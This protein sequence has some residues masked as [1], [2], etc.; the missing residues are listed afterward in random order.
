MGSQIDTDLFKEVGNNEK[1]PPSLTLCSSRA[2]S[3]QS[4]ALKSPQSVK[5][6]LNYR[7]TSTIGAENISKETVEPAGPGADPHHAGVEPLLVPLQTR[8]I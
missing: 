2:Q 5:Y 1:Y 4:S 8:L 6:L 3:C 7:L